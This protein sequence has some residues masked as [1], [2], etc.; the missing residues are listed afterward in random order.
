MTE[1][2][3][4]EVIYEVEARVDPSI[5]G[6]FDAWLPGHVREV[7]ACP[8]FTGAEM[9]H[10]VGEAAAGGILRR[11]QYRVESM[12]AL[13]RYFG[14]DAPRLRADG[15][16]RFGEKVVFSRRL[17]TPSG[18]P[19][20]LPEEPVTC[21]NCGAAVTG[22]FCAGCG[23]S[24]DIHVL[25]M[26]EVVGDVTHSLLHLD[27]RAW[28]TLKALLLK[29]GLLTNEF[30]AGRHQLYLPPFRLYLV[31]S[32]VYF[33]LSAF[34]GDGLVRVYGVA[35]GEVVAPV[36]VVP[37][38][39]AAEATGQEVL[40]QPLDLDL[41]E[42]L[43][44][45]EAVIEQAAARIQEDRGKRFGEVLLANLPKAM[46]VFLPL[47][48]AAALLFYWRPRRLYAEHLVFFLHVHAALFLALGA[49][50]LVEGL[51]RWLAPRATTLADVAGATMGIALA[52]YLPWYVYRAT[53]VVYR[54]GRW[55]TLAKLSVMW[56]LYLALLGLVMAAAAVYTALS[57]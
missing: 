22:K 35:D 42:S 57:L 2:A 56:V 55:L 11:T 8:G 37:G 19:L 31:V 21:R 39:G 54:N 38:E 52:L 20:P 26:H 13:E 17:F 43:R 53:R 24:R 1:T 51:L 28:R 14:Q 3:A 6:E 4:G 18:V 27:S 32:V 23:Q 12:A 9:Q 47:V 15:A 34:I 48:A 45:V 40:Q 5:V 29:P 50:Q 16:A 33:A 36:A 44:G 30:I 10:P 7:I 46:F 41:G 49:S 25:S